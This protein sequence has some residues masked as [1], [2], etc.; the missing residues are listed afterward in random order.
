M[1]TRQSPLG[2]RCALLAGGCGARRG[3]RLRAA[4]QRSHLR[5][6]TGVVR[7]NQGPRVGPRER[8]LAFYLDNFE[9]GGVQKTTLILAGALA[10]RGHAVELLVCRPRGALQDQVP[11]EVEVVALDP[12]RLSGRRACSRC[13]AILR[14]SGRFSAASR[15]RR[16]PRRPLAISGRS[17]QRSRRAARVALYA[18]T[19]HMNLEALLARRLAGVDT[20][21]VVTERNAFRGG[22]LQRGWPGAVPAGPGPARLR[23]GRRDRRGVRRRR[24]R[25]GRLERPAARADR[26]DLQS[27]G[28]RR[29]DRRAKR[30]GR[31]SLVPAGHAAGDHERGPA[32]ARQGSPDADPGVRP[33]AARAAGAPGD[34]RPG[35]ERG[36]DRQGASPR[37]RRSPASSASPTTWRSQGSSPIRS[38]TWRAPRCSR[39]PRST[40]G[41]P[42]S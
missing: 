5:S 18:A 20:R 33:G 36:E 24:R 17:P 9:G 41:C 12:R 35:Q 4:A 25:S 31:S 15:W 39:C 32:R 38:P 2:W 42:A 23:A 10:A 40:R 30:A 14:T 21:V 13:G 7:M 37:C 34:L 6:R 26:H 11:P 29:A 22:H 19:T 16:D 1:R 8:T 3:L 27:G 28:D